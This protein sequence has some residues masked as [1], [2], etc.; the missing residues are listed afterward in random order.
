MRN[1]LDVRT[2]KEQL[3]CLG[4]ATVSMQQRR[5]PYRDEPFEQVLAG[6][7]IGYLVETNRPERGL[8]DPGFSI[9]PRPALYMGAGRGT[10]AL[11]AVPEGILYG[12]IAVVRSPPQPCS[13]PPRP[14][15]AARGALG[16]VPPRSRTRRSASRRSLGKAPGPAVWIRPGSPRSPPPLPEP[17]AASKGPRAG[18]PPLRPRC[19]TGSSRSGLARWFR[20]LSAEA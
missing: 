12:A 11:R 5:V 9:V 6:S 13:P 10:I 4:G 19:R 20:A 15:G 16:P 14:C 1:F 7:G 2:H 3:R 8:R 17:A 18:T